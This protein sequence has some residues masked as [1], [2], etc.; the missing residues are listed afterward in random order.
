M[1]DFECEDHDHNVFS[2]LKISKYRCENRD[3]NDSS[4]FKKETYTHKSRNLCCRAYE[5]ILIISKNF[6]AKKKTRVKNSKF[7]ICK[8]CESNFV[9]QIRNIKSIISRD[10]QF[11]F[12]TSKTHISNI[13]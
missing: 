6:D 12:A 4:N 2:N 3:Y 10:E 13:A 5:R 7:K 11:R 1:N 8:K 9:K